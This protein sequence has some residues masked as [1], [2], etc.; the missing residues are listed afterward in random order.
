VAWIGWAKDG[1]ERGEQAPI[2]RTGGGLSPLVG[3]RVNRR[4]GGVSGNWDFD[5]DSNIRSFG[6]TI[7]KG[8]M[9]C[10][11]KCSSIK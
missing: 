3:D 9:S 6:M 7:L 2:G 8:F 11:P 5:S 10:T 4:S 1:H